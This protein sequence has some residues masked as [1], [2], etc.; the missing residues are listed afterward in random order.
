MTMAESPGG[1]QVQPP[2][3][4]EA[5]DERLREFAAWR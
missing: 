4:K 2:P 1:V 3:P 5:V